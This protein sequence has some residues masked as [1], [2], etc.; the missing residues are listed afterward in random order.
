M[1]NHDSDWICLKQNTQTPMTRRG[2]S[3]LI[4]KIEIRSKGYIPDV[5][6]RFSLDVLDYQLFDDDVVV[7][8]VIEQLRE[9]G[10][11]GSPFGRAELGLQGRTFI[12]LE[13][14]SAF[15]QWVS[16]RFAWQDLTRLW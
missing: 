3:F 5:Y 8:H 16:Q 14:G 4:T 1:P 9:L 7:G 10:Y 15:R 13:P 11:P 12:V 2:L 6:A